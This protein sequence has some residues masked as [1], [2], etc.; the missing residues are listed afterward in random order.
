MANGSYHSCMGRIF[1]IG[2]IGSVFALHSIL[3]K[4]PRVGRGQILNRKRGYFWCTI[5]GFTSFTSHNRG[6]PWQIFVVPLRLSKTVFVGTTV[7]AFSYCKAIKLVPYYL[8]DQVNLLSFQVSLYLMVP[9]SIAVYAG[10]KLVEIIPET[11]FFKLVI[12]YL[13]AISL[14]LI[15][16]SLSGFL[17]N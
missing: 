15:W 1:F 5:A 6:P 17:Q 10:V 4:S 9:A 12:W 2:L 3:D 11:I 7:I 16:N 8:L 13:L 14:R